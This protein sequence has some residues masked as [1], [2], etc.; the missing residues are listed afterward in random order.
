MEASE[1]AQKAALAVLI[2]STVCLA[3]RYRKR[4]W[5]W[6]SGE[7]AATYCA[8]DIAAELYMDSHREDYPGFEMQWEDN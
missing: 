7:P 8:D 5:E 1:V 2:V 6:F 4:L 3:A